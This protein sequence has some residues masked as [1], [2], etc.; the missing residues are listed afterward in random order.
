MNNKVK[1]KEE[2]K[3][4]KDECRDKVVTIREQVRSKLIEKNLG[5]T[6]EQREFNEIEYLDSIVSLL[7][8]GYTEEKLIEWRSQLQSKIDLIKS[9][10]PEPSEFDTDETL[11]KK[12]Q[13]HEKATTKLN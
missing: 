2:L 3:R 6:R 9:R 13:E 8:Y 4:L 11:K 12:I 5:K 10:N 7:D 1:T